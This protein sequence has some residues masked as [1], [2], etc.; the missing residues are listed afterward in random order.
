VAKYAYSNAAGQDFW[1]EVARVTGRP[2][3]RIM[4]SYVD[5]PGVPLLSVRNRCVGGNTEITLTQQRF[6]GTPGAPPLA[7]EPWTVPVC[8]KA[9]DGRARCEVFDRR[10]Q[11]FD[12]AGCNN[13]FANADALGYYFS[14]YSPE[15]VR[16]LARSAAGL[17][18]AERLS[19]LG[20]ESWMMRSGRHDVGVY[21]ELAAALANDESPAVVGMINTRLTAIGEDIVPAADQER[22]Q[23]WIRAR[24]GPALAAL[25]LPGA[26]S[27]SEE[28]HSRRAEL[29]TLV[30]IAGNDADLQRR[31]RELAARY[32]ADPSSLPGT[33][34]PTVLRVAAVAGDAALYEQYLAQIEKHTANPEEYYRFFH[35]LP[36]FRDPALVQRTLQY[37]I[38]PAVRTQD[39]GTLIATALGTPWGR[40]AA[41]T[42]TRTQWPTLVAKLGTF[43][44]I[45]TIVGTL[46]AFCSTRA[47]AE[48]R[49][50]FEKNPVP[51]SNRSLQQGLE[52]IETCAALTTRQ[53]APLS[54]WLASQQ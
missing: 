45:P 31:A 48:I 1:T 50:F 11:T 16:A 9:N 27:D 35:A 42:F 34:A 38:S 47:A 13:V 32:I 54:R 40:E 21:L 29:L 46:G 25:G 53:S 37:A 36:Y 12:A 5:Q 33:L 30:G 18:P 10:E 7:S 2:V 20:D 22:Y 49:Q 43:Q 8:F 3:D 24:F 19:L 44:G 4:R 52:R 23:R 28:R 39:T 51:T 26:A 15:A 6:V 41:W 14:D 17:S